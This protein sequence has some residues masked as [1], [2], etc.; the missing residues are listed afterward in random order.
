MSEIG[1]VK[2]PPL[3]ELCAKGVVEHFISQITKC[4]DCA[5]PKFI[6]RFLP[7][8][9]QIP[10]KMATMLLKELGERKILKCEHMTLFSKQ[11]VNFYS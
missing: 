8:D 5:E 7:L 2:I 1:S 4:S 6:W 10:P 9:R 11:F 3:E